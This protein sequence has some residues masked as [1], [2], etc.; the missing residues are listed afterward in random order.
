MTKEER[1]YNII[2]Q[3]VELLKEYHKQISIVRKANTLGCTFDNSTLANMIAR[4]NTNVLSM[5][6]VAKA[7]AEI[8][9]KEQGMA[10]NEVTNQYEY[11]PKPNW[12]AEIVPEKTSANADAVPFILHAD[13]RPSIIQKADFIGDARK[14]IIEFGIRLRTFSE[15]FISSNEALYKARVIER[16]KAGVDMD[17]YVLYPDSQEARIYFEDRSKVLASEKKA[18]EKAKEAIE[19]LKAVGEEFVSGGYR[20]RFRLWQYRHIPYNHFLAIDPEE[21]YGKIQFS[22]YLY[23]VRRAECPVWEV[24]Q[25]K[26]PTLYKKYWWSLQCAMKDAQAISY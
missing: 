12:T 25:E 10:Y 17:C 2:Q 26:Q 19:N 3:G 24:C 8:V 18:L 15:Y 7:I 23:G 14:Q 1:L 16:L 13:G 21:S 22:P 6:R 4:R 5:Q 20:G 11:K 9:M